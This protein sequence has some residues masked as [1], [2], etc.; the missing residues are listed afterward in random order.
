MAVL[1]VIGSRS[2]NDMPLLIEHMDE[3]CAA[4][5]VTSIVSGG[6]KGADTFTAAHAASI[7]LPMEI[8][9]PD[10]VQLGRAAG[11]IRNKAI[12]NAATVVLAFWDGDSKGTKQA[13]NYAKQMGK[14]VV[15][16]NV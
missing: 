16:V 2:F 8:F 3:I 14:Q 10:W 11:P 9:R 7:G 15:L 12:V 5:S 4:F 13:L 6:A 1:A